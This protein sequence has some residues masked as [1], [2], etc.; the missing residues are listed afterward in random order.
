[1]SRGKRYSDEGR[2]NY[3]KVFAVIIAI[4]VIIMF[5]ILIKNILSN[6]GN[7]S[8][9]KVVDYYALYANNAWGIVDSEG[10][11][12]V[13][14]MYQEMITVVNNSKDVFLC[15]YDVN[16]QTGEYKTKA[17]NKENQEIYTGYDKIEALEN[18]DENENLWYE[19]DILK[20]E[21]DGKYG[22]LSIDGKEIIA[23]Q[24]DSIE[25]LKGI[26]D[27]L[28]VE[29]DGKYGLINN[30]GVT[31][32]DAKYNEISNLGKD[33]TEGYITKDEKN[34]YGVI[35]YTGAQILENK[36]EK[37]DK[38]YGENY[39]V[40]EED[41]KQK[42]IDKNGDTI[43][44]K[45]FDKIKQ[46]A[47]SGIIFQK[48]KKYGVM[49]YDGKIIIEA[50]YNDLK[51][52]NK[53]IYTAEKN[54]KYGIIDINDKQK[55]PFEYESIYYDKDSGIYV[56]EKE[57]FESSIID[58]EFNIKLTGILS[59][60]NIE[61]GFMKLKIG[62]QYKYYN[63]KFEEKDATEINF[64]QT[65]FLSRKDNKY[66]F[67]DKQGNIV[68]DY[69]YDDAMEQNQ[70]GFIAVNKDGLWGALNSEGKIIIEPKYNLDK[71]L[72]IDFIGK[73]H[74]GQDLNMNYYC[75]K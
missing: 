26:K 60:L 61:K 72:V 5:V 39:F 75:E 38:I 47:S 46:I 13:E 50:K 70:Y 58:S 32:I 16:E 25:T 66:G 24:Y 59:E 10:E 7:K 4:I 29:K 48:D 71:N 8:E 45:G 64:E 20:I 74:L 52:I 15:T 37:I 49:G 9:Y 35:S 68:V 40:I 17:I 69:I 65:L 73:W 43:I 63:F 23:P 31:I 14:P 55:I 62:E 41:G 21:K 30:S 22:I 51:E 2:L 57:N 28:I 53:D 33:N 27:S 56:A 36:Y 19:K 54:K 42:L 3:K 12:V 67:L 34:K 44:S 11:T 1:M 18:Y 6:Q